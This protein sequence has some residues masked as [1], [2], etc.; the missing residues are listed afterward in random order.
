MLLC[1]ASQNSE[2][3]VNL[4]TNVDELLRAGGVRNDLGTGDRFTKAVL[5]LVHDGTPEC[6]DKVDAEFNEFKW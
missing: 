4:V 1:D 2:F 3:T 5:L 6:L